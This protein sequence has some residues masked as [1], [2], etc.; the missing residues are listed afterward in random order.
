M[1]SAAQQALRRTM[2]LYSATT[3]FALACNESTKIIEPI[4]SRCAVL[5]YSK[6]SDQQVMQRLLLVCEQESVKRTEDGLEAIIFTSE[7]DMRQALN[8]LQST[9]SGYGI[10]N[11][12][13][14]FKVCDQ[15]H[16]GIVA[17]ILSACAEGKVKVAN[18]HVQMLW[19]EGYSAIDIIQTFFKMAKLADV[20]EYLKLEFLREIG[21]CHMR[22]A[23]G[24]GTLVQLTGL[25]ACLC[26]VAGA[27]RQ[28][29]Q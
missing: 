26:R 9:T 28:E 8:N 5:R 21:F 2:E 23:D 1:T 24:V 19:G 15:P 14:V 16:P 12:E 17:A 13:N 3:R 4:Q 18:G 25:V 20:A 29:H 27:A 6:L 22:V 11:R 10:V 7:G